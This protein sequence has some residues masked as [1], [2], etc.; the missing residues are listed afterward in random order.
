VNCIREWR[1]DTH[2]AIQVAEGLDTTMSGVLDSAWR[3]YPG[4]WLPRSRGADD[5]MLD[6]A[7][8]GLA[9]RGLVTD[10]VVDDAG[11]AYRQE[12]EDRLDRLCAPGWQ[13]FGAAR[14]ADFLDLVEPV[15]PA[16]VRRIDETA[17]PL[18]MPAARDRE[19]RT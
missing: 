15:G 13:H 19:P 18:W 17:G 7:M 9:A 14:T 11:I 5:A 3:D 12:L 2:W 8:A 6:A 10:G 16:F 4:D 1:G